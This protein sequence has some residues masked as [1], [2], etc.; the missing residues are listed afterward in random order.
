M[1]L[2]EYRIGDKAIWNAGREYEQE[3]II[4]LLQSKTII[5]SVLTPDQLG[6]WEQMF[7]LMLGHTI[8]LIKGE[9]N[10]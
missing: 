1:S 4:K 2:N 3:R 10:V 8:E 9:T 7:N 5:Y 6:E